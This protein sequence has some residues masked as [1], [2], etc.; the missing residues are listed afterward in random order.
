[1]SKEPK[2]NFSS[3]KNSHFTIFLSV[4]LESGFNSKASL[5]EILKK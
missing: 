4:G 3:Q 2:K 5:I 1:M